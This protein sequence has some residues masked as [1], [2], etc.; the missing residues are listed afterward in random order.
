MVEIGTDIWRPP[1]PWSSK[2]TQNWLPRTISKSLLRISKEGDHTTSL[3]NLCQYS[4]TYTALKCFLIFGRNFLCSSLCPLPLVLSLGTTEKSLAL[5]SLHPPFRYLSKV[6]RSPEPPLH[7]AEQ[8]QLPW[9][10]LG[11]GVHRG[12]PTLNSFQYAQ[13]SSVLEG[14]ELDTV[15]QMWLYQC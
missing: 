7:H 1:C 13:I 8:S 6:I 4:V 15:L 5:S 9:P 12:G 3:G 14:L 2:A 11:G 10:F